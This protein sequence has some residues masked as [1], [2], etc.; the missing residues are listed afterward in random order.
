MMKEIYR[1]EMK[2]FLKPAPHYSKL[3]RQL[4][5][6]LR[7][8]HE[9]CSVR[10]YHIIRYCNLQIR[11]NADCSK[12]NFGLK[13]SFTEKLVLCS[14]SNTFYRVENLFQPIKNYRYLL[15]IVILSFLSNWILLNL[16][17]LLHCHLHFSFHHLSFIWSISHS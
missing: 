16:Y 14:L 10:D 12:D 3:I 5:H 7:L 2:I 15:P 13:M 6:Y 4:I 11:L 1:H 17:Y 8:Y 9:P